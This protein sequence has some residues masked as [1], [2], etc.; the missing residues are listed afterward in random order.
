MAG[1]G[2][3]PAISSRSSS[4]IPPFREQGADRQ[5]EE[6]LV[7]SENQARANWFHDPAAARTRC[8]DRP[9]Q[10][11]REWPAACNNSV[12]PCFRSGFRLILRRPG[13]NHGAWRHQVVK[14]Y[15]LGRNSS[16]FRA[17]GFAADHIRVRF[18]RARISNKKALDLITCLPR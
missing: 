5:S 16:Q 18:D 11:K 4:L 8:A 9:A 12:L 13:D 3:S 15:Q 10:P 17:N 6:I 14:S 2:V 1:C 7:L